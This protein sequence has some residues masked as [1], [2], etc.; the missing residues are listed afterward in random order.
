MIERHPCGAP[1]VGCRGPFMVRASR[2][3]RLILDVADRDGFRCH[4]CHRPLVSPE[5]PD[6]RESGDRPPTIDHVTPRIAGGTDDLDN[7]VL[8]CPE[9]NSRKGTR[10]YEEFTKR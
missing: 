2:S 1:V 10:T 9:C 8:A 3:T 5:M 7:L 4:Y 6:V